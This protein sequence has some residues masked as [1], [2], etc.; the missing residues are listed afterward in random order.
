MG[1]REEPLK[2]WVLGIKLRL[3]GLLRRVFTSWTISFAQYF[4]F[5]NQRSLFLCK[6]ILFFPWNEGL[7]E[8]QR[9][10]SVTM[11]HSFFA[12]DPVLRLKPELAWLCPGAAPQGLPH[13]SV[14]N[15][16]FHCLWRRELRQVPL[17]L[18]RFFSSSTLESWAVLDIPVYKILSCSRGFCVICSLS[19]LVYAC[20]CTCVHILRSE[21]N[22]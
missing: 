22:L 1:K 14:G 16:I 7:N 5:I 19:Y 3:S 2:Q 9:E 20:M 12:S 15:N 4:N 8:H 21:N 18:L 17:L 10:N 13:P 11:A 6:C